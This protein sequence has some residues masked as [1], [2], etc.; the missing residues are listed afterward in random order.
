MEGFQEKDKICFEKLM[1]KK[2][3]EKIIAF[4]SIIYLENQ[5]KIWVEQNKNFGEIYIWL[6]ENYLKH[7]DPF[8]DLR[9]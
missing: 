7:N 5:K 4:S 9:E 2:R 1:G 6:K 8:K 3:E